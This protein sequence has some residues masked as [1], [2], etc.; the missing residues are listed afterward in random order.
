MALVLDID[1]LL[2]QT[3]HPETRNFIWHSIQDI[4]DD[5]NTIAVL[6]MV[7]HPILDPTDELPKNATSKQVIADI[8]KRAEGFAEPMFSLIN[9]IDENLPATCIHLADWL[10]VPYNSQGRV[11]L[12]GDAAGPMTSKSFRNLS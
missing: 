7:S 5:G 10:P 2:F 11:A 3:I 8:K 1:P 12:A 6:T 4:S 9:N